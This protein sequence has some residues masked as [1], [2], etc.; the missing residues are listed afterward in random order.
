MTNLFIYTYMFSEKTVC[1]IIYITLFSSHLLA[2]QVENDIP[3][4]DKVGAEIMPQF[5]APFHDV[6]FNM[7]KLQ[8]PKFPDYSVNIKDNGATV[9]K[10]ITELVNRLIME[11]SRKGGGKVVIPSGKW[12]S[13][14]IILKSNVNLYLEKGAEIEFSGEPK[15]YLPSV[16]TMH[17]GRQIM[18]SGSFIYACNEENIAITGKG[19]IYGPSMD[20]PIRKN[21]NSIAWI[22]KDFP[23][24]T[25]E[26]IFDG[27]EGRHF[28]AP[29]V[30]APIQCKGVFIEGMTIERCMFWNVNPILCEDVIIRGVTV[31]SVGIPSGDGVDITC[32][33]NVLVEYCTMNCGDDCYAVKGGR[34]EEGARMGIPTENVIIRYCFA[35]AGH[36]GLTTGSETG[37]GIK[38]IYA[39]NCVFDG[40]DMP[41]RF[42]TRRPR[43]GIT[44]NIFY[45]K[46]RIKDAKTVLVWDLL[47][48]YNFVGELANR[49][50]LRPVT[51]LTPT[52]RN[53]RIKNFIVEAANCFI[54]ARGIPE[55]PINNVKIED[56]TVQCNN[57]MPIMHD[58]ENFTLRN[59][60]I[61]S[62]QN[63]IHVLKG[64][65][66][67][68]ENIELSL[69]EN[70][71][72]LKVEGSKDINFRN[73][74]PDIKIIKK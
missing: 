63:K 17:E 48:S 9:D 19:H 10:P 2:T 50:P 43:T 15:D 36:G 67:L 51:A 27:M 42:K 45:E 29:K 54:S 28:F 1:L 23:E 58:F 64:K 62:K 44:E 26:R 72:Y 22:E 69:P 56:G 6:P 52:V 68:M 40:T 46:L 18:G 65:N 61:K 8:Y 74:S 3:V 55:L 24:K 38:N 16:Y 59:L 66:L 14:R 39:Y 31:N 71:L 7:P 25:E 20:S 41:L 32:S 70:K 13:A 73:L 60:S 34:D 53:V 4:P 37:G 21:S 5:I 49:L 57:L 12:K 11:T 33:K 35:K 47:G 30:I